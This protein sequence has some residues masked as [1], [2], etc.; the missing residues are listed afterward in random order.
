MLNKVTEIE[1]Y[2]KKVKG[3]LLNL[4]DILNKEYSIRMLTGLQ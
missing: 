4:S 2:K 1:P 3:F